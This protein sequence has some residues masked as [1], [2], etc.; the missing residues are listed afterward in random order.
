M[1]ISNTKHEGFTLIELLVVIAIIAILAAILFPVFAQAR[2]K[3]R[4]ISCESNQKQIALGIL[5]YTQDYDEYFPMSAM[6]IGSNTYQWQ[7]EVQP[8][9]KN[10]ATGAAWNGTELGGVWTCPDSPISNY[11]SYAPPSDMFPVYW[12]VPGKASNKV[13]PVSKVVTVTDKIMLFDMGDNNNVA[14]ATPFMLEDCWEWFNGAAT[15][16][17]GPTAGEAALN[18]S[19]LTYPQSTDWA[20]VHGNCDMP[21]STHDWWGGCSWYPN[22]RHAG[23]ENVAFFDGHVK[24]IVKNGINWYVNVYNAPTDGYGF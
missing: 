13:E 3:A 16:A 7:V 15:V 11:D 24:S 4:A 23:R 5:M 14:G 12:A 1:K 19:T 9:I 6:Q 20:V 8:Y 10:G 22:A 18:P 21:L 2:E 17:S